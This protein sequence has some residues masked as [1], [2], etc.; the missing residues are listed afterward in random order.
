M[1]SSLRT[2]EV[3]PI[4]ASWGVAQPLAS[5]QEWVAVQTARRHAAGGFASEVDVFPSVWLRH[6]AP[7]MLSMAMLVASPPARAQM[8]SEPKSGVG[9]KEVH[10]AFGVLALGTFSTSLVIGSASGN[11]GKLMD[12]AACCPDG[13]DRQPVWRSV[14]RALVTTGIVAYS[15]AAALA[16]YRLLIHEPP[17]ERPRVAHQAH[18]WLALGHGALFLTSAVT[19]VLMSRAQDSDPERFASLA[20]IHVASNVVLVPVLTL[21]LGD[22]LFE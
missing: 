15:S 10:A 9:L 8:L 14:D 3:N 22:I 13:G 5:V 1:R 18:R 20:R 17:S 19:G 21:A 6:V 2:I 4:R 12:P 16:V 7:L 11:L